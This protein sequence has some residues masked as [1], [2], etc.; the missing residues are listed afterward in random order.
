M[1]EIVDEHV[2]DDV[3]FERMFENDGHIHVYSPG[4]GRGRQPP[5]GIFSH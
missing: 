2:I 4:A 5:G 1:F 3:S